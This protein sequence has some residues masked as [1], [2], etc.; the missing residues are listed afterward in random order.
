MGT[1]FV[2]RATN[3]S[4]ET[5]VF[6]DEDLAC[7]YGRL[8]WR[9]MSQVPNLC[10]ERPLDTT[11]RLVLLVGMIAHC[12]KRNGLKACAG[13]VTS[14]DT[15]QRQRRRSLLGA[16]MRCWKVRLLSCYLFVRITMIVPI[17]PKNENVISSPC[18]IGSLLSTSLAWL[19]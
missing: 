8:P 6:R 1:S 14:I 2:T 11:L 18:A 7:F 10:W 19:L 15:A 3:H 5:S 17:H 9:V 16:I 13:S 4:R 12:R